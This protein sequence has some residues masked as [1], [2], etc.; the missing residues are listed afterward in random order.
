MNVLKNL[1]VVVCSSLVLAACDSNDN[2]SQELPEIRF[3]E[4]QVLHGS[5]DAPAVNV[6]V[7]GSE[8]LSNVDYKQ[9][10]GRVSYPE[11]ALSVRVDGIVGS[12]TVPVIDADIGLGADQ[13]Y[14]IIAANTVDAIEPIVVAQPDT[15]VSAGSARLLVVHATPGAAPSYSLPVDVYVD[16]YSEPNAPI[17]TSAPIR[18]DYKEVLA[19]GPIEVA[20]GDYQV[21][22]TLPDGTP[23]YDSGRL[24]L[25]DG[26]DFVIAAVPNVSGGPAALTLA[27]LTGAGSA[28][29]L[30]V[31]TPAAVQVVHASPDAPLVDILVNGGELVTDLAFP[32]ATGFVEVPPDTYTVAV[33]VA[34]NPGAV[35]IGPVDLPLA[36]GTQYSVLAVGELAA[37]EPLIL[38]DDARRVSTEAKVRIVHASPAAQD[39][40]IYVTAVGANINEADPALVEIPFKA[41]TGFLSLPAGSYDVT[42]TPTGTKDAAIGPATITIE[43]GGVYTAIARDPLPGGTSLGLIGLNDWLGLL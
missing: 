10:S 23:V 15:A 37:I 19:G 24:P 13:V 6:V 38:T 9:G 36:A 29:F 25:A 22:V 14:S 4:I 26:N 18:F 21:R 27:A 11:G 42:V 16:A 5:P 1:S 3:S 35:A 8:I 17:G 28:E 12:D 41:N 20:A 33:T 32:V 34:D 43:N 7:N 30:D 40:D 31:N 39:V 2:I